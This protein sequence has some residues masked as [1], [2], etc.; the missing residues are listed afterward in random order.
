VA[1]LSEEYD[2][3]IN[4]PY[5]TSFVNYEDFM[6]SANADELEKKDGRRIQYCTVTDCTWSSHIIN[7]IRGILRTSMDYKVQP[8][9][10]R[11]EE[12]A[13]SDYMS[14]GILLGLI[15]GQISRKLHLRPI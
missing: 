10:V 14:F 15:Q 2:F 1:S 9:N 6:R 12:L 4:E 7:N 13:L 8:H 3:I 11:Y 5:E